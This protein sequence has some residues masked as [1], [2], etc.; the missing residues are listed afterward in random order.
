MDSGLLWQILSILQVLIRRLKQRI[1][2]PNIPI[3]PY[4]SVDLEFLNDFLRKLTYLAS[5]KAISSFL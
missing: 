5:E 1:R 3:P 2:M 4:D